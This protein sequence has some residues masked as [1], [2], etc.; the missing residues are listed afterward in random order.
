MIKIEEQVDKT[1]ETLPDKSFDHTT[2]NVSNSN[3]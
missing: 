2:T 1:S 3:L